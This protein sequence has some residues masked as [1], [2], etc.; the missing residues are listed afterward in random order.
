[1]KL[2]TRVLYAVR[3]MLDLAQH[4]GTNLVPSK[5]IA[6]RQ[7]ISR[8]YLDNLMG[9]LRTAGLVR[10]MRGSGGGFTLAKPAKQI[11]VSD[12]WAAMEGAI[13]LVDCVHHPESCPRYNE[14]I[15]REIWQEAELALNGVF[16]SWNLED[17]KNR[18]KQV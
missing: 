10:T 12:I 14:C 3:I 16:E 15:T 8:S 9:S 1:M 5:D 7:Q 2:S 11:K 6:K 17:L 4:N 13:C 18:V